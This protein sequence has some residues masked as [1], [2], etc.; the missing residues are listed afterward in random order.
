MQVFGLTGLS[1]ALRV[2]SCFVV[3]VG[4]V[5]LSILVAFRSFSCP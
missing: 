4:F 5:G 3:L 1:V 2:V